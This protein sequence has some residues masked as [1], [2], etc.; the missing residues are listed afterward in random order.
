MVYFF[1][2]KLDS[3]HLNCIRLVGVGKTTH[4]GHHAE[5]VV[6]GGIDTDLSGGGTGNSRV[7]QDKLERGVVNAR[8]IARARGLVL[9]R[10]EGKRVHVDTS[11]GVAGV[12]LVG[13]DEVKVGTFTLRESVLTV[14]LQLGSDNGIL[15]PAV[16]VEGRLGHDE[17]SGIGHTRETTGSGRFE[18]RVGIRTTPLIIT[19]ISGNIN[20]SAIMKE[21]RTIDEITNNI[22]STTERHDGVREGINTVSVVEGLGTERVVEGGL[23][24]QGR[25]VVNVSIRLN[26]KDQL[27][28]GVVEVQLDLVG[29]RTDGFITSELELFNEVL[30]GVL[31]HTAALISVQKHVVNV[32]RGGNQGL[33]VGGGNTSGFSGGAIH[34][35]NGPQALINGANVKVD[36]DFVVLKGNEGEGKTG[37][38]AVPELKGHIEG[39]FR[40]GIAGLAHLGG[41]RGRAGTVN[42]RERGVSDE[43]KLG[44]VTDHTVV[45]TLLFLGKGKLVPQVHPVT[46]LTVNALT[47]N[48]NL[49]LGDH[50]LTREVKPAGPHTTGGITTGVLHTLV[51]FGQ[52]HL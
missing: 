20:R 45:T 35:A 21:T 6:V 4:T 12:V 33:V 26:D 37:V 3:I 10:A 18:R 31:G 27:L 29:G 1:I 42:S 38:S 19:S 28:A 50:L 40:E 13:L 41:S 15:T 7:R 9:F 49:N 16:H 52:S 22:F 44:G 5:H 43:G 2:Q 51:D 34:I 25:A 39:G 23:A 24:G 17:G 11:V 30:V 47:T 48:F 8:E 32:E 14:E 36:L 46:I